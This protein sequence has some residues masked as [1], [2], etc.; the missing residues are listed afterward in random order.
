MKSESSRLYEIYSGLYT[1]LV[2]FFRILWIRKRALAGF[3][4][5]LIVYVIPTILMV[6]RV[7]SLG[8]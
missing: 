7:S 4:I 3:L 6:T 1:N 2:F 5:L 8:L